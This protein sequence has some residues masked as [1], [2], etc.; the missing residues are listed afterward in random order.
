MTLG[1]V[2]VM[3]AGVVAMMCV[4]EVFN[5]LHSY[6]VF[7]MYLQDCTGSFKKSLARL[8]RVARSFFADFLQTFCTFLAHLARN[9]LGHINFFFLVNL[10]VLI[11][12][13]FPA[14]S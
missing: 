4:E 14:Q 8:P 1:P 6:T 12:R 10:A 3:G 11:A 7:C 13:D 2:R 9:V 5:Y